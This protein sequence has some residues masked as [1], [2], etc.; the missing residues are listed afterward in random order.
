[1]ARARNI[2]PGIFKNEILGVADPIYTLLFQGLWLL[3]DREGRLED[4]PLR[5]KAEV[6]PYRDGM[7]VA[8]M[9]DWLQAHGFICRYVAGGVA[10]IQVLHFVKHQNPHKNEPPSTY[11]APIE[12][13]SE[14]IGTTPE[15]IGSARADPGFLIPDPGF[16]I[17]E[18]AAAAPPAPPPPVLPAKVAKPD[19]VADQTWGDWLQ[20]R[21]AKKAP[22]T[23]T[24]LNGAR[25]QAG[26]AGLTVEE[27]LQVWCRRGSTGLEAAWLKPEELGRAPP[28]RTSVNRQEAL[29]ARSRHVAKQWAEEMRN[30]VQ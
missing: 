13:I 28:G 5:I 22:V 4:R 9:L 21:K 29:E 18:N 23:A 7:D 2:K 24:V 12:T 1:M 15:K 30:A 17:P 6:F 10:L 19:D 20:L 16:L 3:A 11:P 8:A 25:T 27:F 14:E 26:L